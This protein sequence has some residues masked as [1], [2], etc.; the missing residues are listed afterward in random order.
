MDH[1]TMEQKL[2]FGIAAVQAPVML[3]LLMMHEEPAGSVFTARLLSPSPDDNDDVA[4]VPMRATGMRNATPSPPRDNNLA[5]PVSLSIQEYGLSPFFLIP[6]LLIVIFAALTH[7]LHEMKL[8]DNALDYSEESESQAGVWTP[9]LWT[10]ATFAHAAIYLRLTSP[11]DLF[12]LAVAIALSIMCLSRLCLPRGEVGVG[13]RNSPL[14]YFMGYVAGLAL[15]WDGMRVRHGTHAVAFS[16]LACADLLLVMGHTYDYQPTML[17][18]GN[19]R[20]V[21][22]AWLGFLLLMAYSI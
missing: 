2:A 20:L 21:Y 8:M 14:F 17:L 12:Q 3:A 7:Q 9:F 11:I 1:F 13:Q 15:V 22:T 18:V 16:L 4:R 19:C 6:S 10:T 5:P